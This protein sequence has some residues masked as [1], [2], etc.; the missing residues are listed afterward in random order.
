MKVVQ[1]RALLVQLVLLHSAS[2][3]GLLDT[4]KD[5]KD[6]ANYVVG[7]VEAAE[8]ELELASILGM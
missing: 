2:S 1:V 3:D 5:V 6:K 7:G 4:I 8:T